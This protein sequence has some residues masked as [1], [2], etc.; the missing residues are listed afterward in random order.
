MYAKSI[1]DVHFLKSGSAQSLPTFLKASLEHF[2]H[3]RGFMF[4]LSIDEFYSTRVPYLLFR[5]ELEFKEIFNVP[6]DGMAII[7]L[8]CF[9][10]LFRTGSIV[11]IHR[12]TD[13]ILK[14]LTT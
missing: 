5:D 13:H 2:M 7:S 3:F 9:L 4:T 6:E 10:V 11:S 1:E 12:N 8:I 14:T